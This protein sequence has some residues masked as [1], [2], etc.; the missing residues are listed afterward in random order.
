MLNLYVKEG[1]ELVYIAKTQRGILVWYLILMLLLIIKNNFSGWLLYVQIAFA[2][3]VF[4][5]I[6]IQFMFKIVDGYLIYQLFFLT[7]PIYKKVI[8][9]NQIIQMKFKRVGWVTKGV[10]IQVKRGFNIRVVNFVPGDVFG[11]LINFANQYNIAISKTKD[12][13]ILED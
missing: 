5:T 8:Y 1:G 6:F 11:E 3:F 12:Y 9:P 10:I 2:V 7:I 4:I 13:L